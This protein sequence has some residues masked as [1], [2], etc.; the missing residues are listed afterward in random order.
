MQKICLLLISLFISQKTL[1]EE[2]SLQSLFTENNISGNI[3]IYNLTTNEWV[4]SDENKANIGTLPASTFKIFNSLVALNEKAIQPNE[5]IRWDG[6][7]NKFKGKSI[8]AWNQDLTLESAFKN[9]AI[10]F[11]VEISKKIK[12]STYRRY[13][14][15]CNYS[16]LK[17]NEMGDDFWNY[18]E[19]QITP[20]NQVEF[21]TKLY[22]KELPFNDNDMDLIKSYMLLS[23]NNSYV[24]SGKSGWGI[25]NGSDIGWLIGFL[26]TKKNVYVYATRIIAKSSK[27]PND[28]S[29][30]R[31]SITLDA[32]RKLHIIE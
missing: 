17:L 21:L 18:G 19:M 26:E 24:F 23:S 15:Q 2:S 8:I 31:T 30:L 5:V 27:V 14:E 9:S 12:R 3:V 22:K 20:K 11:Y 10:W 16:N 29:K 32:F 7:E 4:Y 28:F 13:L 25:K 6:K 1:S